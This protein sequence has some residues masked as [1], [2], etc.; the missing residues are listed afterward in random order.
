VDTQQDPGSPR[1]TTG[2]VVSIAVLLAAP[3]VALMWVSSYAK[4]DPRLF[5]FPFFYWYQF[6]W[7]FLCAITTSIAYRLLMGFERRRR[8]Y[9]A[10]RR[11]DQGSAP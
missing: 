2:L 1:P 6:M 11:S 4:E 8:A 3:V 10:S 5:G 7:V 9:E